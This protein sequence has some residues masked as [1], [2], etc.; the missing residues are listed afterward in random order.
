MLLGLVESVELVSSVNRV[1]VS[2]SILK[3]KQWSD[4]VW[5][6]RRPVCIFLLNFSRPY[7]FNKEPGK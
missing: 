2:L 6:P 3:L 5:N 7:N 4:V 1:R